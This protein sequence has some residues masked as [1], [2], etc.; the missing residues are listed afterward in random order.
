MIP[1]HLR[2]ALVFSVLILSSLCLTLLAGYTAFS[3]RSAP[4]FILPIRGY[5]PR[6]LIHGHYLQFRINWPWA[7]KNAFACDTQNPE[8]CRVCLQAQNDTMP[9]QTNIRLVKV[10]DTSS[11]TAYLD[12]ISYIYQDQKSNPDNHILSLREAPS[13]FFV[14]ERHGPEL[15]AI[16]RDDPT[17]FSILVKI[18]NDQI[19]LEQLLIEGIDY[20]DYL[21]KWKK[22][23]TAKPVA[24]IMTTTEPVAAPV[25]EPEATP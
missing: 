21:K 8:N 4:S 2:T 24:D 23:P 3:K 17:I 14:D 6:D 9:Y 12:G 15:D 10:E 20:R 18:H 19:T 25:I 22:Q 5:D 11:C 1:R 7:D 13:R 16:F